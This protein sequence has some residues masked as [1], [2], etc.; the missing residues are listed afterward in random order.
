MFS[1]IIVLQTELRGVLY[2]LGLRKIVG[3]IGCYIYI[4]IILVV[5]YYD[6]ITH[7][8]T[9]VG[10]LDLQVRGAA[11]Y[12][13]YSHFVGNCPGADCPDCTDSTE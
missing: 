11:K 13:K 9:S 2:T 1:Y 12:T 8:S 4:C 3:N 5:G 6:I 10:I 7:T